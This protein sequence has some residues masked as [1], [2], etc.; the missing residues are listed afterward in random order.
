MMKGIPEKFEIT[1]YQAIHD[2]K[3]YGEDGVRRIRAIADTIEARIEADKEREAKEEAEDLKR[4]CKKYPP[5]HKGKYKG[6]GVLLYCDGEDLRIL[7]E[8]SWYNR[9]EFESL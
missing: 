6:E 1:V 4:R 5:T 3:Y 8:E 2:A 7:K 9:E